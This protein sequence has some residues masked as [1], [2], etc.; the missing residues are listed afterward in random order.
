VLHRLNVANKAPAPASA[1]DAIAALEEED[2]ALRAL[3]IPDSARDARAAFRRGCRGYREGLAEVLDRYNAGQET[4][5]EQWVEDV[6]R[7]ADK[8]NRLMRRLW[9]AMHAN[10]VHRV[11]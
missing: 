5:H 11:R 8:C 6:N 9:A 2:A 10:P 3:A 7:P 1:R 4:T